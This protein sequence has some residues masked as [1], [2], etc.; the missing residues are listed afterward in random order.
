MEVSDVRSQQQI[1]HGYSQ[2]MAVAKLASEI[3]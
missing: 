2:A 1:H 3:P